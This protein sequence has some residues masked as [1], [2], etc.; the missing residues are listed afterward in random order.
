MKNTMNLTL[1]EI[2]KA[3]G[4]TTESL[5]KLPL[6]KV[7]EIFDN[8]REGRARM[9]KFDTDIITNNLERTKAKGE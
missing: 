9:Y 1:E 3:M 8:Y 2:A 6:S 5:A 4:V 7:T